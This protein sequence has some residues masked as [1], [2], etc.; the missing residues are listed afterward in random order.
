MLSVG[1]IG[2]DG[3]MDSSLGTLMHIYVRLYKAP[4][5]FQPLGIV[6]T[7]DSP[8]CSCADQ[9]HVTSLRM[10]SE[11]PIAPDDFGLFYIVSCTFSL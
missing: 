3:I 2:G 6:Y 7:V 9:F 1:D 8:Y 5:G 11:H 10:E 4:L